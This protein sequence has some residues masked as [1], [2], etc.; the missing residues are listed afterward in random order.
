M[1]PVQHSKQR[2]L[3]EPRR[4]I[5]AKIALFDG[6]AN[7][8]KQNLV[9]RTGFF[10]DFLCPCSFIASNLM[11]LLLNIYKGRRVIF[12]VT[13]HEGHIDSAQSLDR[14]KVSVRQKLLS[15]FDGLV[16]DALDG[17]MKQLILTADII[18]NASSIEPG[19]LSDV[20]EFCR[21][22]TSFFE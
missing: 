8:P 5:S 19:R 2:I 14:A 1:G 6:T 22:K 11:H 15:E 12:F 3:D 7:E 9:K 17:F 21:L 18:V 4:Q 13:H 16:K 20:G 10:H